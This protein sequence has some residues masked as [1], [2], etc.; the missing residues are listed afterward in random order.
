M[1]LELLKPSMPTHVEEKPGTFCTDGT[2]QVALVYVTVLPPDVTPPYPDQL[3]VV[4]PGQ[5]FAFVAR[6]SGAC[7]NAAAG[8]AVE[9]APAVRPRSASANGSAIKRVFT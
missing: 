3:S 4:T 1:R 5:F 8:R 6:I 9:R 2:V 7:L